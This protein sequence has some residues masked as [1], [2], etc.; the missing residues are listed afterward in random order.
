MTTPKTEVRYR[1]FDSDGLPWVSR[2]GWGWLFLLSL[3][4]GFSLAV[5]LGIYLGVWTKGKGQSLSSLYIYLALAILYA[6]SVA[7][8]LAHLTSKANSIDLIAA[9][10]WFAGAFTLRRQVIRYY[11]T[12]E[13]TPF[14]I[15]PILTGLFSVWYICGSLR[16]DYPLNQS[17]KVPEGVLKL[18]I[19]GS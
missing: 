3:L 2:L 15:N 16:A 7:A 4:S 17:G 9:V 19:R 8:Y 5:G 13:G 10:L 12:R 6:A 18:A 1:L 11:S 14:R